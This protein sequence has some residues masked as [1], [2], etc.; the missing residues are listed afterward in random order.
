MASLQ[1]QYNLIQEGKSTAKDVFLKHAKA[2]FP[3]YIPNHFDFELTTKILKNKSILTEGYVDLTPSHQ[4]QS[5]PKQSF[6]LA[7]DKFLQEAKKKEA[8]EIKIKADLKK[9]DKSVEDIQDKDYDQKNTKSIDN[10]IFDQLQRGVYTEMSKDPDQDLKKVK[11]KVLKNLTKDPIYY[12]KNSAFGLEIPGYTDQLPGANPSKTDKMES[13]SNE[14]IKSNVKDS[15]TKTESA[16]KGK[17]KEVKSEMTQTSKTSKGV[18]KMDM[19]GKEKIIKLKES[20]MGKEGETYM[21]SKS[22]TTSNPEY[23]I[24]KPDGSAMID[25]RFSSPEEAK[26]Y[27]DKKGL[28]ISD[29]KGYNMDEIIKLKEGMGLVDLLSENVT[30]DRLEK[31][32]KLIKNE[33]FVRESGVSDLQDEEK[34]EYFIANFNNEDVDQMYEEF[35]GDEINEGPLEDADAKLAKDQAAKE[36]EAANIEK[37]RADNKLKIANAKKNV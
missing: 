21:I 34:L 4:I 13:V 33:E 18:K 25:M 12:T 37:Q 29:Q 24:E 26:K 23:V 11:E 1:E 8:E 20:Y 30:D 2:L 5:T 16:K 36:A 19:P 15:L 9:T 17:P 28:K 7:F 3:Q 32:N 6:E 14:K 10:V 31:L 35:F 22:G 27:A